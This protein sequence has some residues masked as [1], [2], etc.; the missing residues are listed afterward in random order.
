MEIRFASPADVP[1]ILAL[2]QQAGKAAY[3]ARPDMFRPGAQKYA[4][5]QVLALLD[6]PETPI[7]VALDEGKVRG[8]CFCRMVTYYRDPVMA[9]GTVCYIEEFLGEEP[10]LYA[11]VEKYARQRKCRAVTAQVWN[12]DPAADFYE[13]Q[14]FKTQKLTMETILEE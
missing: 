8:C 10:A 9:D 4:P 14:G 7:F 11:A 13:K 5:S 1:G 2:L 6:K 3:Q 12:W